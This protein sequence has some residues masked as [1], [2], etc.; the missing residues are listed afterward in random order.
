MLVQFSLLKLCFSQT[1]VEYFVQSLSLY[2]VY[3]LWNNFRWW[4]CI[5]AKLKFT[6]FIL[7]YT[8]FA[9]QV[10]IF[11]NRFVY[12][13]NFRFCKANLL[14]I[15]FDFR[16]SGCIF[17]ASRFIIFFVL[18]VYRIFGG[19]FATQV[20]FIK[21]LS[22]IFLY[23]FITFTIHHFRYSGCIFLASRLIIVFVLFLYRLFAQFSLFKLRL[24]RT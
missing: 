5:F 3:N 16:Y 8:I 13:F 9:I 18:F 24:Y 1:S 2:W 20:V 21:N 4:S 6:I 11:K 7:Q 22:W 15:F 14:L 23:F 12:L 19:I 10:Y 17:I